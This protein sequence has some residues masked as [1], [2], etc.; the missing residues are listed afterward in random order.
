M[1]TDAASICCRRQMYAELLNPKTH[2]FDSVCR[3]H[4]T[5]PGRRPAKACAFLLTD[6]SSAAA[7]GS[8]GLTCGRCCRHCQSHCHS[9]R[10]Q[11]RRGRDCPTNGSYLLK[12]HCG[13]QVASIC[14]FESFTPPPCISIPHAACRSR[15]WHRRSCGRHC[16]AAIADRQQGGERGVA[17]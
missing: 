6:G 2:R 8:R 15:R 17:G 5:T 3:H 13:S 16:H 10:R 1:G 14:H 12:V 7:A 11:R 9:W 4:A